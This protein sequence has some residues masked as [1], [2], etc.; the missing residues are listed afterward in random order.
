MLDKFIEGPIG[1][2]A[3]YTRDWCLVYAKE[4]LILHRCDRSFNSEGWT[5]WIPKPMTAAEPKYW[6]CP[7]MCEMQ[8][9]DAFL[10]LYQVMRGFERIGKNV[11]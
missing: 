11:E 8:P 7:N 9:P 5:W 10:E 3:E 2:P 4:W 1:L 6:A